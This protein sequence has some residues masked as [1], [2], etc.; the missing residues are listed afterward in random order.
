MNDYLESPQRL[1]DLQEVIVKRGL[2]INLV[3]PLVLLGI[4]Y[5]LRGAGLAADT[6]LLD[7]TTHRLL[8]YVLGAIALGELAL[9]IYLKKRTFN[10]SQF[11]S[12][13]GSSAAFAERCK[14]KI[15]LIFAIAASPAVYGFIMYVLGGTIEQYL[16]FV[17]IGLIGF[18]L[19]R[20]GKDELEKLWATVGDVDSR[21]SS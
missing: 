14:T 10:A 5:V 11:L 2:V 15:T 13:G 6:P 21:S 16:F 1:D 7:E 4:A 18:R 17:L 12:I 19:V 3:M 8:L 9:A 20:P